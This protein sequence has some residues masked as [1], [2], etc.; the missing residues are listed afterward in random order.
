MN[1]LIAPAP[2]YSKITLLREIYYG[3]RPNKPNF[4]PDDYPDLTGKT[5]IVTGCNTGIGKHS[6]ELLYQKN[7]N[8]IGIVRSQSKGDEAR[9]D[10]V[11]NNPESKGTITIV[12]GCDYMDL[13]KIPAV[14]L[15]IKEVLGT[16]ALNI[17]IHNAG[18]MAPNN[19]GTS[20]QGYEAMFQTNVLGPQLLQHFI[21]PLFLKNDDTSLKR[22]VWVSSGAHLLAFNT[23]GINWEDPLFENSPTKERPNN[24]VL[25]G[26]SKAANIYQ[27][28]A[29]YE[30]NKNICEEIG[31]VS[32]SC[33][34]GNLKTDLQRGWGFSM[35]LAKYLMWDGVY[36]AYSEL[37]GALSP[38]LK[39]QDSGAYIVP[40]GE[41]HDPREDI[42]LGLTNGVAI[43][44]WEFVE[45]KIS[46]Y[47]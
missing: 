38:T 1:T 32:V 28:K 11:N 36:G 16:K 25:Y 37:Y 18:L 24:N 31:C 12:S 22:I 23:Y 42:K 47:F 19:E 34:P 20:F 17:I 15:K 41:I 27:A 3:F 7:C 4:T 5:A 26:Q 43:K 2:G 30:E 40:F 35:T 29:W 39:P 13:S 33:Y 9:D 8:V 6:L 45:S 10:I 44:L 21:D 14:G 46:P